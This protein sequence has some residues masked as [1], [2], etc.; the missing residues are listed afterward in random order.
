[1]NNEKEGKW[2]Y[3]G[4]GF[5]GFNL[6]LECSVC[7]HITLANKKPTKCPECGAKMKGETK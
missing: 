5:Y 7:K 2:T 6:I 4:K 3:L 1:M